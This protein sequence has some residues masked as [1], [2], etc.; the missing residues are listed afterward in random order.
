[1]YQGKIQ[2]ARLVV[3]EGLEDFP[4]VMEALTSV[5]VAAKAR[6]AGRPAVMAE[7]RPLVV[8]ETL[9]HLVV[10]GQPAQSMETVSCCH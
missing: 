3:G 6:E 1:M 5:L 10:K 9:C 8:K 7:M 2:A 4:G